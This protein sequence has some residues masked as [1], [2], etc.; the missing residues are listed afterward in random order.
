MGDDRGMVAGPDGTELAWRAEGDGAALVFCNGLAND[1]F[2]WGAVLAGLAGRGRIVTWDYPGHGASEPAR[3]PSA[4]EIVALAEG[5]R[6]VV[7]AAIGPSAQVVLLGYSTGCQLALEAWRSMPGRIA[8]LVLAL[9]TSGRPFD[10]FFGRPR[11]GRAAH[12]LLRATPGPAM[13]L[14]MRAGSALGPVSFAASQL[15]GV[16]ERN[17]RYR[18]FAPW[19]NHMGRLDGRS[20]RAMGLAAQRHSAEDVLPTVTVPTLVVAGGTDVFTPPDRAEAMDR[21]IPDSELV[22]LPAA[23]HAGLVGHGDEIANAVASFLER[24]ELL[25]PPSG[26]PECGCHGSSAASP[27]GA[28]G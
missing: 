19:L 4:V 24:R 15:M 13:G 18:E 21:A 20:F 5:L 27:Q 1:A 25:Q 14:A 22:F 26:Q 11:L 6:A 9:G 12:A 2:Q 28:T 17:I 8:G 10:T 16:T 3:T 7:D 23:S